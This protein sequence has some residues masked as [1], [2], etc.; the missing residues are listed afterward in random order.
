MVVPPAWRRALLLVV[1][2]AWLGT[3]CNDGGCHPGLNCS[4]G[5]VCKLQEL[6]TYGCCVPAATDAP[7]P[8]CEENGWC[9]SE[10]PCTPGN[11]TCDGMC[12]VYSPTDDQTPEDSSPD[13]VYVQAA[14]DDDWLL[15]LVL[16]AVGVCACVTACIAWFVCS[17][18]GDEP[19]S[20][21]EL[22]EGRQAFI[23][24][25]DPDTPLVHS[26]V[27]HLA[28]QL[29]EK[30]GEEEA[31]V[32]A[33]YP[34]LAQAHA[35]H[36]QR[37]CCN[38]NAVTES[39]GSGSN[40]PLQHISPPSSNTTTSLPQQP[41]L[42]C[43]NSDDFHPDLEKGE[44]EAAVAAGYL[45]QAHAN[46]RHTRGCCNGKQRQRRQQAAAAHLAAV[47]EHDHFPPAA[48]AAALCVRMTSVPGPVWKGKCALVGFPSRRS[49]AEE[50]GE[51][52]AAVA[53]GY[54]YLA[55]AH[56]NRRHTRGCCNGKQRQR[57]QQA[58]A[59]H[60]A[61]VVEHDHFPPAAAAAAL[62]E[63][64][65]PEEKGEEE[66]AVAAG[67]AYLAQAH[68]NRRQR[69]CCNDNAVAESSGSGGNK[70][71]QHISP[72]SSNT[73]T[74]LPQQPLLPCGLRPP[75]APSLSF[76]FRMQAWRACCRVLLV[77]AA[78][79]VGDSCIDIKRCVIPSHP[80]VTGEDCVMSDDAAWGCCVHSDAPATMPPPTAA[81][82]S[83]GGSAWCSI[84]VPC[85][86]GNG[87][88]DGSCCV[89]ESDTP[90]TVPPLTAAPPSCGD[91]AWCSDEVP[92][93]PGNGTCN[94]SCCVP[95]S[96]SPPPTA[97]P[98]SC[99]GGAWCSDEVACPAG[100]GTCDDGCCVALGADAEGPASGSG[101]LLPVVCLGAGVC[102]CAA[103]GVAW[104]ACSSP[105]GGGNAGD[106]GGQEMAA[107]AAAP[108]RPLAFKR[109]PEP[110]EASEAQLLRTNHRL[111]KNNSGGGGGSSS[112]SGSSG[113]S[114]RNKLPHISTQPSTPAGTPQ[115]QLSHSS[116]AA[117]QQPLLRDVK[118][119][120]E[121]A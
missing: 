25:Y 84:E 29:A 35:N 5:F 83:C 34:Y 38:D 23:D 72:P 60:L 13:I 65:R 106:A 63:L 78:A 103:A 89:P 64:G 117:I 74:S 30:N 68:A 55:Q 41:L 110:G 10:L 26:S 120:A 15:P 24:D 79:W 85:P 40:K 39:S 100:N 49:T 69:G 31:A 37:G 2:S 88:C 76:S 81:P 116:F 105:R 53:A 102:A 46:R 73:T 94:G 118:L 51:E 113:G 101:W 6:A 77:V 8:D 112:S 87:T 108:K 54:P 93:P 67:Y 3:S 80:C 45:A 33:R 99:G 52:E 4:P 86:P 91:S 17:P 119:E 14:A 11:G 58:A 12:C 42:P 96:T 95:E 28:A 121:Q 98:P 104:F 44:E 19:A 82:P 61:A 27:F 90:P 75:P 111:A 7:P 66:A 56:A 16:L 32:A 20:G 59:A 47:V 62:F 57:R 92:C 114:A 109:I 70:P 48:A 50:K 9:S 22:E 1:S 36:H 115:L 71:P 107:A 21:F 18:G 97:A 43:S